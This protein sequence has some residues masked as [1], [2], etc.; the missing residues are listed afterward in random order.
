[1]RSGLVAIVLAAVLEPSIAAASNLPLTF[2][3]NR[4]QAD[5]R[6]VFI[7]HERHYSVAFAQ[8]GMTIA[9]EGGKTLQLSFRG[10]ARNP[11]LTGIEPLAGTA[12][13]FIGSDSANWVTGIPTFERIRYES[14]YPGIDV[15]CYGGEQG[16]EY[17]FVVAPNANARMIAV[18]FAGADRID[19][20]EHGDLIVTTAGEKLRFRKPDV[21]Q[22]ID[23]VKHH[24]RPVSA[25]RATRCVR[26]RRL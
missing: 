19:I 24:R 6:A 5:R 8:S 21:H 15:V 10:A 13:Y 20:D 4:G 22:T 7:A 16:L 26:P 9:F 12:S 11:V 14:V 23:G 18:D 17:D 1:M 3:A 25:E 2:E